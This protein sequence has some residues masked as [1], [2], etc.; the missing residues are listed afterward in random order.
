VAHVDVSRPV[1]S[2]ELVR[3]ADE[4]MYMAK[5]DR[6]GDAVVIRHPENGRH[7]PLRPAI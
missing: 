2:A 7:L 5:V 3:H 1:N 4:A 6:G